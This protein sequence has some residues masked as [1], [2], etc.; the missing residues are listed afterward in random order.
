MVPAYLRKAKEQ[1]RAYTA[2]TIVMSTYAHIKQ[3]RASYTLQADYW[4][5]MSLF[6][7]GAPGVIQGFSMSL[8]VVLV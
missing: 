6:D 3:K 2:V 8:A 4:S 7:G 5:D 1:I